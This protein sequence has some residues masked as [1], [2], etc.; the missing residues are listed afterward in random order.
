M[1]DATLELDNCNNSFEYMGKD[2]E[3]LPKCIAPVVEVV[4][5]EIVDSVVLSQLSNQVTSSQLSSVRFDQSVRKVE[6]GTFANCSTLREVEFN[7][8]LRYI[9][10]KSFRECTSLESIIFP[11]SLSLIGIS[12]FAGCNNLEEVVLRLYVIN[13]YRLSFYRYLHW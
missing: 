9:S 1:A 6:S 13:N 10:K 2:D 4:L 8:D 7:G 12:A 3:I 11:P 5:E